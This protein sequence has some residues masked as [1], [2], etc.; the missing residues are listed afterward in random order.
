MEKYNWKKEFKRT[1]R[2]MLDGLYS[3]S[4]MAVVMISI[5]HHQTEEQLKAVKILI[6]PENFPMVLVCFCGL[7]VLGLALR[8]LVT[9]IFYFLTFIIRIIIRITKKNKPNGIYPT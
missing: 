7:A 5:L 4:C 3:I 9:G 8:Y 2:E 1:G 6:I